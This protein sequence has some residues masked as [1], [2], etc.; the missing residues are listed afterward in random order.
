MSISSSDFEVVIANRKYVQKFLFFPV[1]GPSISL[2]IRSLGRSR[3]QHSLAG[4]RSLP[5]FPDL[6]LT[7]ATKVVCPQQ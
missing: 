1:D 7:P 4:F 3:T 2:R 5:E 6:E